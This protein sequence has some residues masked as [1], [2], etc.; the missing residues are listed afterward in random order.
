MFDMSE[1]GKSTLDIA[2]ILND[3][4]IT[5]PR[6]KPW[7]KTSVHAILI[8]ETYTGTLIWGVNAKNGANPVR[9]E[10][11]LSRHH[12]HGPVQSRQQAVAVPSAKVVNPRRVASPFLLSGLVKCKT[13]RRALTGQGS[14]YA[15]FTYYVCQTLMKQGKG[16]CD[17]PRLNARR[18]EELV[19][20]RIRT[21]F[22]TVASIPYLVE[23][24]DEEIDSMVAEHVKR[25]RTIKAE[26]R[27]VKNQLD[28]IWRY[29]ATRDDVDVA[30][31][32]ARM[33]EYQDRQDR[34]GDAATNAREALAL[35]RSALG[36]AGEIAKYA[37]EMDDFLDRSDLA[38]RRAFIESFVREVVVMPGAALLRYTM[39]M[40]DDSPIPGRRDEK[41]TL[42]GLG[43]ATV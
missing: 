24:V 7:G 38:E 35:H 19:V 14:K 31:T 11:R 43:S 25:V 34:L 37:R 3:E 22:L 15:R 28:R 21:N 5:S 27:D 6:G 32:S 30:M 26:L 4:G 39:S 23:A 40:Q 9:V 12:L 18:F 1:A 16:S 13:C 10:E 20:E 41:L 29:I 36:D 8:N 17:A 42:D 2:R 33:A